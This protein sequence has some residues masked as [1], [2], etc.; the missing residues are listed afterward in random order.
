MPF[1]NCN[2][3]LPSAFLTM[4]FGTDS[5][6]RLGPSVFITSTRVSTIIGSKLRS[7]ACLR[8]NRCVSAP[9]A[10]ITPAISTAI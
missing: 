2:V 7:G 10:F 9:S 8:T 4:A 6:C 5:V 3:R 1:S